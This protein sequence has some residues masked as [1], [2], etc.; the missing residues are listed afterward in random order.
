MTTTLS[1][2]L[3]WDMEELSLKACFML[4]SYKDVELDYMLFIPTIFCYTIKTLLLTRQ[5]RMT[6]VT[7]NL[8]SYLVRLLFDQSLK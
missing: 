5:L 3:Q 4:H 8:S 2:I 1:L 6:V 7:K